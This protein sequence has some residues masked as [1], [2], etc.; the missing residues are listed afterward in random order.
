LIPVRRL[1]QASVSMMSSRGWLMG[2]HL[3]LLRRTWTAPGFC[4][5]V[6]TTSTRT[7]RIRT[8]RFSVP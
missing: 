8:R 4:S 2:R 1:I 6:S 5:R 3:F 7:T